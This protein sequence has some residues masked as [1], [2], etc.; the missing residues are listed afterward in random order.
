MK[1]QSENHV[2]I[3]VESSVSNKNSCK[4]F[5]KI[6]Q[7]KI[8]SQ[9][10]CLL[11]ILSAFTFSLGGIFYIKAISMNGS[12]NSILRFI[13]QFISMAFLLKYKNISILGPREHRK[14]LITRSFFGIFGVVLANFAIKYI[15]ISDSSAISH[16]SVLITAVLARIFLKEKFGIQH[17]IALLLSVIGITLMTK[18]TF[19]FSKN[20]S[21]NDTFNNITNDSSSCLVVRGYTK[22]DTN[23]RLIGIIFALTGAFSTGAIHV[24]IKKLC[25]N[26][27]HFG[28]STIYGTFL[29]LPASIITSVVLVVTGANHSNFKCEL[30]HFVFD[31]FFGLIGA[32]ISVIALVLLN[33]SLNF[34]DATKVAIV[35]TTGNKKTIKFI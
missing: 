8:E 5:Y 15:D 30:D 35:R 7:L 18:P 12:D 13:I 33:I 27:I 29:G 28:V 17:L 23:D 6:F 25:I 10:G 14:L 16:T 34:E 11:A 4:R 2:T 20:N 31:I 9:F 1:N 24:I 21:L 26:K 3:D 19:I 22:L 32:L